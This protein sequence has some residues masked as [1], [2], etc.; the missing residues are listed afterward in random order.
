MDN[1]GWHARR[2][3]A[4]GAEY[5]GPTEQVGPMEPFIGGFFTPRPSPS[6]SPIPPPIPPKDGFLYPMYTPSDTQSSDGLLSVGLPR[7]H[8]P[9]RHPMHHLTSPPR[10]Q[11]TV[12]TEQ[13]THYTAVERSQMFRAARMEPHLQFMCGPLLKSVSLVKAKMAF[14]DVV[15]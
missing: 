9:S 8:V 13:L 3:A 10:A 1:A 2:R 6:P 14:L 7:P 15:L 5:Y 11:L 4:K 12:A